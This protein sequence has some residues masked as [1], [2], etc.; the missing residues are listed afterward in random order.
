[1]LRNRCHMHIGVIGA[2]IIERTLI[3]K[4]GATGA[5]PDTQAIYGMGW[6]GTEQKKAERGGGEV[7]N[8]ANLLKEARV[9][10]NG[11]VVLEGV[12]SRADPED[13]GLIVGLIGGDTVVR[14]RQ[15]VLYPAPIHI[16]KE[17]P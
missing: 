2:L 15:H 13:G 14:L 17:V 9:A 4:F 12:S 11:H 5:N 10:A 6:D 7:A 16:F 1:M 8:R 3:H